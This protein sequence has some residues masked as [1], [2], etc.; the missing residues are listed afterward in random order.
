MTIEAK[1]KLK[2]AA[3]EA[4]AALGDAMTEKVAGKVKP[5][6]DTSRPSDVSTGALKDTIAESMARVYQEIWPGMKT[7][8]PRRDDEVDRE[9]AEEAYILMLTIRVGND[10]DKPR[11]ELKVRHAEITDQAQFCAEHG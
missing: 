9:I 7:R 10:N 4:D 11:K 5:R 6:E 1:G 3:Q 8:D 2:K